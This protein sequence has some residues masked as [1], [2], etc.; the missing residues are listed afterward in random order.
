MDN[1]II[2]IGQAK[3]RLLMPSSIPSATMKEASDQLLACLTLVAPGGMTGEERAAWVLIAR[4][5]LTGIPSDLI[6]RGCA[7]AK[8]TCRFASEIVPCIH[9]LIGKEW[10]RRKRFQAEDRA[11][12][13]NRDA[14]RLASP[15]H[16]TA[17]EARQI[18]AET[19]L[20]WSA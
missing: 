5:T 3:Q 6:V 14:P 17:E 13:A 2:P 7:A 4:E 19:L 15:E 12:S 9:G 11:R 10:E 16:V 20:G 1:N 18:I 8:L